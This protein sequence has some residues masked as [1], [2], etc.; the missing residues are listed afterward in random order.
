MTYNEL[1]LSSND[2]IHWQSMQ[3]GLPK[4]LYT[5]N[6][7]KQNDI[8]FAGQW[9]GVYRKTNNDNKWKQSSNGL[10]ANFAVT[11]LKS[12]HGFLVITT[13]ERKLK[14]GY[15]QHKQSR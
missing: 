9:D 12:F 15:G 11:N 6:I 5:F 10:P 1:L 14:T 2:G 13:S 8:V 4:N 7:L 3:D